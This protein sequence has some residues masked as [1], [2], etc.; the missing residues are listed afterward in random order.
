MVSNKKPSYSCRLEYVGPNGEN[1]SGKSA[2]FWQIE[3]H[4]S[5]VVRRWGRIG[6]SGQSDEKVYAGDYY[7][8]AEAKAQ[9]RAKRMKGYTKEVDIIT[10]IGVMLG[11]S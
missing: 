1:Q 2:K 6:T 9:V 11:D 7:A 4:G 8:L 5:R 3:V 10:L